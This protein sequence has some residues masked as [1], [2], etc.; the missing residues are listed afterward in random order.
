MEFSRAPIMARLNDR[1]YEI[2]PNGELITSS[3]EILSD[4]G[5]TTERP[6]S[7]FA[8]WRRW[9]NG[10]SNALGLVGDGNESDSLNVNHINSLLKFLYRQ[11]RTIVRSLTETR[12]M[13]TTYVESI[14]Y[15]HFY[16]SGCIPPVLHFPICKS[17]TVDNPILTGDE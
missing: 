3:Q 12:T 10:F 17:E 8:F 9:N 5:R 15:N 7:S 6:A 2:G 16:I 11:A 13:T 1:D 14:G 4:A